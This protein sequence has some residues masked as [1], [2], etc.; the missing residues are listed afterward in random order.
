MNLKNTLIAASVILAMFIGLWFYMD[1]KQRI[2]KKQYDQELEVYNLALESEINR[3][4]QSVK[5]IDSLT[6][7]VKTEIRYLQIKDQT[8]KEQQQQIK[9]Q[10][11]E[12]NDYINRAGERVLDSILRST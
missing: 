1:Q 5:V 9:L 2:Q 7:N 11:D 4:M 6:N 12:I 10:R 8:L 3:R